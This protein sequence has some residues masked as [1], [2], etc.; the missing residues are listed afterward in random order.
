VEQLA[1]DPNR[2]ASDGETVEDAA[3]IAAPQAPAD[4]SVDV[5][6]PCKGLCQLS[7]FS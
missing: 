6:D 7:F 5:T 3:S 4:A 1:G 2:S